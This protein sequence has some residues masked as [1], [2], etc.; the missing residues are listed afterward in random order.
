MADHET[1]K[2]DDFTMMQPHS[3]PEG[4]ASPDKVKSDAENVGEGAGTFLGGVGGLAMGAAAGPIGMVVGALAGAV[5]GWWAGRGVADAF[6]SQDDVAY[7]AHYAS[8]PDRLA[9][10]SYE[11]VAPAYVAGHLA[12][13]NPEYVG[14]SFEQV[15][16]DLQCGW[17]GDVA[18]RCAEWPAVRGYARAAFDR[19]RAM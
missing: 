19:A 4:R 7:R 10:R 1:R 16:A 12:G 9:D 17:H 6:A 3:A 5:G 2:D 18:K 13:R 11:Q 14:R 8:S 15:E